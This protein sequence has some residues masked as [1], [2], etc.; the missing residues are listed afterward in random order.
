LVAVLSTLVF[1]VPGCGRARPAPPGPAT[2]PATQPSVWD[3]TLAETNPDGTVSLATALKAFALAIGPVPGVT[4]P[5]GPVDIVS[6]TIAVRRVLA[7]WA[8][9]SQEQRAA[10]RDALTGA[11]GSSSPR[12]D[13]RDP[14]RFRATVLRGPKA[15]DPNIDCLPSDTGQ[16]QAFRALV[17]EIEAKLA[18][19]L[20]PDLF[21]NPKSGRKA[22]DFRIALS[23]NTR[24]LYDKPGRITKMYTFPCRAGQPTGEGDVPGC[25]IHVNPEALSAKYSDH[26]RRAF[27]IHEM[28]HCVLNA[29]LGAEYALAPDWYAEGVPSWVETMLGGGDPASTRDFKTYLDLRSPVVS[30]YQRTYDGL[31]FFVHLAETGTDVWSRIFPMGQA[32][33]AGGNRAGWDAAAVTDAFLDSWGSGLVRG[34]YPGTP[35]NTGAPG[36]P[37]D[38]RPAIP[39]AE[40]TDSGPV[41]VEVPVAA[42]AVAL[43]NVHSEVVTVVPTAAARGRLST[44]LGHDLTLAEAAGTTFCARPGGCACPAGSAAGEVSFTALTGGPNYLAVTGGPEA[45]SVRMLGQSLDSFCKQAPPPTCL[46][47]T[48]T[49]AEADLKLGTISEHGGAGIKMRIDAAGAFSVRFAGMAPVQFTSTQGVAGSLVYGGA[50]TGKLALPPARTAN[51]AW[52]P[53]AGDWSS[54]TATVSL[55]K[56]ITTTIGPLSVAELAGASG[57]GAAVDS[58]PFGTG[59]WSCS[60]NTLTLT[61]P[62]PIVGSWRFTRTGPP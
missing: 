33:L 45:A 10:V 12:Q 2:G 59:N 37:A 43:A 5:P 9:L 39:Q 24:Q 14:T 51:G 21:A 60:G 48:W 31:G 55:T 7:H 46:V 4:P 42:A 29:H 3:Q 25:T 54:V 61:S 62:A 36:L 6:G 44:G 57:A 41:T 19:H 16:S 1:L 49:S 15:P 56:P 20:G 27:L 22:T 26:D 35:W 32:L 13:V 17:P 53:A 28:M 50:I 18:E 34:R 40:L 47:G 58:K 30:L 52:K 38:Y 23:V 8:E 11:G